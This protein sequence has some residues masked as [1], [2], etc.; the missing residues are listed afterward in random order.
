MLKPLTIP[1][2]RRLPIYYNLVCQA[3]ERGEMYI[4]S[5][6][7]ASML[8]IDDSQVRKDI[9]ATGYVGK[10]KVGFDIKQLKKHLEQFLGFNKTKDAFLIGIGNLG[11][12]IAKYDGFKKYGLQVVALFDNDP[13]KVGMKI[14]EKDVFHVSKLPD[15]VSKMHIQV[16]ILTVPNSFAQDVT[17][18]LIASGIKAIWNFTSCTLNVPDEVLVWNESL[19]CSYVTFAQV[20]DSK[21]ASE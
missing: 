7:I 19:G 13:H 4:S 10:P 17:N 6:V 15:L 12:A 11:I 1:T 16:A 5:P 21:F 20:I 8:G 2:L 14:G 18:Y 3:L 9:S